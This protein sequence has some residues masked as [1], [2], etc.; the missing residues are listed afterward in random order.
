MV[1]MP[2]HEQAVHA[3][4]PFNFLVVI[5]SAIEKTENRLIQGQFPCQ[6]PF[7]HAPE[8]A[9]WRVKAAF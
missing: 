3:V 9:S 1:E 6:R 8:T 4:K 7:R 2:G 5:A